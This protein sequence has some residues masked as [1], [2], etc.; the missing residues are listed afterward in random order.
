[1]TDL[2][3]PRKEGSDEI[4]DDLIN[5]IL[6][7]KKD[8]KHHKMAETRPGAERYAKSHGL[9]VGPKGTDI[10]DDRIE[11][12]VLYNKEGKPVMINGYRFT[13][14]ELSYRVKYL[15]ENNI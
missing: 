10:N 15:E 8:I 3:I 11:D 2:R 6:N 4:Y 1:M 13:P 14:S 5:I 7:A 9:R 12:I